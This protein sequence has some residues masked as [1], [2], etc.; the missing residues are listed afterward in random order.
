[1]WKAQGGTLRW[2]ESKKLYIEATG[3][4]LKCIKY[5]DNKRPEDSI[6]VYN[7]SGTFDMQTKRGR[8]K[9]N[10]RSNT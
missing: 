9:W 6:V 8:G 10:A 7:T 2:V 5:D 3:V 1:L 4:A